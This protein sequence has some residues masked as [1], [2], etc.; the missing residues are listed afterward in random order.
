MNELHELDGPADIKREKNLTT[1]GHIYIQMRY[2]KEGMPETGDAPEVKFNLANYLKEQ[3]EK[4]KDN[5]VGKLYFNIIHAK[6]LASTD[7]DISDPFCV[8]TLPN[9]TKI[10]TEFI[11]DNVNPVWNYKL[12]GDINIL[13]KVLNRI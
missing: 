1:F 7:D 2:L 10:K 8:G 12:Q 11:Q 13:R 5:V 3:E 4:M 6:G 9:G